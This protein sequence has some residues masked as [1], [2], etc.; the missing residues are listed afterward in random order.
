[1][2]LVNTT[3]SCKPTFTDH[4]T[5]SEYLKLL[6]KLRF[7]NSDTFCIYGFDQWHLNW[8]ASDE[9]AFKKIFSLVL[10]NVLMLS[11]HLSAV[12]SPTANN[13]DP[14]FTYSLLKIQYNCII[15]W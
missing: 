9:D 8:E 2:Y 11:K 6:E 1:M 12:L 4:A 3:P 10:K 7:L 13:V 5:L 15:R 14:S